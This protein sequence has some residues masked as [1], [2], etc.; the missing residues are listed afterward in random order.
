MPAA[1]AATP[2][3]VGFSGGLDSTVLL[4]RL[5]RERDIVA[6]GLSALHV[7]H[8]LQPQADDWADHCHRVCARMQVALDVVRV[9]VADFGLG[10]E[11]AARN[12]RHAA[13][14]AALAP[15]A[16][17]ALGHHRDDQAETFLL[18]AMR[19][20]GPDGLAAMSAWRDFHQGWLWRPLL[21]LPRKSLLSY[22]RAHGLS[23]VEDPSNSATDYDRNFLRHQVMPLLRERWPHADVALTRSANLSAAADRLLTVDD[24]AALEAAQAE[25][26]QVLD[27][28]VLGNLH[29][30]RRARVLRLWA[31]RLG[32]P[33]LPARGVE[34]IERE[35]LAASSDSKACF[36][37]SGHVVRAWKGRL[38]A[39]RS[40]QAILAADYRNEWDGRSTLALPTGDRLFFQPEAGKTGHVDTPCFAPMTVHARQGG[41]RIQLPGRRHTHALKHVLQDLGIPPWQRQGLPLLSSVDGRLLA[42]GDLVV[43]ADFSQRL[44]ASGQHLV[45]QRHVA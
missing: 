27:V 30:D 1:Q 18:R 9:S 24:A 23:W 42:A 39:E 6:A 19:A 3:L 17:L 26:P 11:A 16:V 20:S 12:A 33:P 2:V 25:T 31:N 22:G 13:F 21:D 5:S 45:W 38:Y 36:R 4:H 35:L 37:W 29:A 40:E 14:K 34:Q 44:R 32:F 41:E 10:P 8:G 28:A 15:N 7:H 43:S